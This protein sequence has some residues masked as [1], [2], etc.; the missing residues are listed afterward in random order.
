MDKIA[1]I[2]S[3]TTGTGEVFIHQAREEGFEPLIFTASPGKYPFL[4]RECIHPHLS[5]TLDCL[6]LYDKLKKTEGLKAVLSTS[7][8]YVQVAAEL[9]K[10]LNLPHTNPDAILKCRD[11]Y[12]LKQ[13]LEKLGYPYIRTVTSDL[14]PPFSYP[15]VVKPNPGTGSIGVQLIESRRQLTSHLS[16]IR[17]P[18]LLQEYIDGEEYSAEVVM[19]S[20]EL[21]MLGITKKYLG[22]HPYFVEIGHD[23]PAV[24]N[25][26]HTKTIGEMI[27]NV[28]NEF[29]YNFGP[30]H[31]EFRIKQGQIYLIEINPRLAGGMIPILI[32]QA[33]GISLLKNILHMYL[34]K[35]PT[36]K[37]KRENFTSIRFITPEESGTFE[38]ISRSEAQLYKKVGD[39]IKLE[40]NFRDRIGHFM[41]SGKDLETCHQLLSEKMDGLKVLVNTNSSLCGR[42][43]LSSPLDPRVKRILSG[44]SS[45][46]FDPLP[47]L[48][49]I[50]RAH[51]AMLKCQEII[52]EKEASGLMEGIDLLKV[53]NFSKVRKL[54]DPSVGFYLA[55]EQALIDCIGIK[56]AGL[57]HIGRSRND[58]NATLQKYKTLEI[59]NRLSQSLWALRSTTLMQ[60][61]KYLLL[62]MPV[63][64]QF[65]GAMPATLG[66]YLTGVEE[67]LAFS[68]SQLQYLFPSI[69]T[70]NMGAVAGAGTSYPI[71]PQVTASHLGFKDTFN[72]ALTAVATRDVEL[73]LLSISTT[74]GATLS[75][76]AQDYQLWL[77]QEFALF[78]LPDSLC[79]IS[80][81]MPQKKNP[82]LLEKIKGKAVQVSGALMSALGAV[83]KTPFSN[84]VEVGT[85]AMTP[86]I[87]S[88]SSLV[89][90]MELSSLVIQQATP[91]QKNMIRSN[92]LGLT[93]ATPIA[94]ELAKNSPLTFR[95][96]HE[97]V[98]QTI[99]NAEKAGEDKLTALLN[100]HQQ[101]P[102]QPAYWAEKLNFGKGPG[103]E[104][105]REI[106]KLATTRL[107][108]DARAIVEHHSRKYQKKS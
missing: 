80:S 99:L 45:N 77:T 14:E 74:L 86:L 48:D 30:I 98:G 5:E 54:D 12:F 62:S 52:S 89:Q 61:E 96:A 102:S 13:T 44:S 71:D 17:G 69:L 51:L 78:Q 93:A 49:K 87:P 107:N 23:F 66:Y 28:L 106:L 56:T 73:T 9:G 39:P 81:T 38:G 55:Y 21:H 95:E 4:A 97:H 84:S 42:G 43:R 29:D 57:I 90:A 26:E 104:S 20:G 8:S 91:N 65:Q 22:P 76:V 24:M 6:A 58:I 70:S 103:K 100:L 85:E 68:Q 7:D 72:H 105:I 63:Y 59:F 40:G 64:S 32:E 27:K 82:Y 50:N 15:L 11:K 46:A 34:G 47:Y 18:H 3:N 1:F 31:V 19:Q 37:P 88:L 41:T 2:E 79:G 60:A 35:T 16:K 108:R 101:F 33:K 75:R 36:F 67:S 92:E 25:E 10:K 83:Y 94:E 53:D